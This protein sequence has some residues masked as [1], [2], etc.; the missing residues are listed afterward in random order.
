MVKPTL[1]VKLS[2]RVVE[3]T[4]KT[5]RIGWLAVVNVPSL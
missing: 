5:C 2:A 3:G 1:C 4:E